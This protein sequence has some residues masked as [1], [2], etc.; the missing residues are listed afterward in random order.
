MDFFFFSPA[1]P[2]TR[3][4]G[5]WNTQ[6]WKRHTEREKERKNGLVCLSY[7]LSSWEITVEHDGVAAGQPFPYAFEYSE[8]KRERELSHLLCKTA[9]AKLMLHNKRQPWTETRLSQWPAA[10]ALVLVRCL[11]LNKFYYYTPSKRINKCL[12]IHESA[13]R[14]EKKK[15][16]KGRWRHQTASLNAVV[17][18][19]ANLHFWRSRF[20]VGVCILCF[21]DSCLVRWFKRTLPNPHAWLNWLAILFVCRWFIIFKGLFFLYWPR[22]RRR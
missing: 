11:L 21:Y 3:S 15:K 4:L 7:P 8:R 17:V 13:A 18:A 19:G 14:K 1:L 12:S 16:K 2:R 9:A 20:S 6:Q 22:T 5:S 10:R